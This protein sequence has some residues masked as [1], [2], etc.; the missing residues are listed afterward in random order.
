MMEPNKLKVFISHSSSDQKF[1]RTLKAD[2]KE[3]NIETWV[4]EDQLDLGDSLVEKLELA[5][6]ES[7]HFIIVLSPFSVS[8]E[9]VRFELKKALEQ[10]DIQL[11]QK[12]IPIKYST[13]EIPPE[14]KNLLYADLSEDIR[15]NFGE[16]VK[17][18]TEGYSKFLVR[19]IK[20]IRSPDKVLTAKDKKAFKKEILKEPSK[21]ESIQPNI[22]KANYALIGYKDA[23]VVNTFAQRVIANSNDKKLKDPKLIRPILLPPLLKFVFPHLKYGDKI[24]VS[25]DYLTESFGHFAGYRKDDLCITLFVSTRKAVGVVTGKLYKVEID[26][27]KIKFTFLDK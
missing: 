7:S 24:I 12:I 23:N 20:A 9:W 1:V 6:E 16:R 3:N 19:L 18:I 2:L 27:E 13:C 21:G 25:K 5:L 15:E 22:L 14:L 8:S 11:M 26:V 17:F 10:N 4:D